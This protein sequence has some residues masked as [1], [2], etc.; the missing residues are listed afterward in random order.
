MRV[1]LWGIISCAITTRAANSDLVADTIP[2]LMIWAIKR[3]A[4]LN[5]LKGS[6]SERKMCA[7]AQLWELDSLRNPA[8]EWAQR[9]MSLA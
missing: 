6:F 2:N 4:P 8:S 9:I 3:T 1:C 5:R 7:P